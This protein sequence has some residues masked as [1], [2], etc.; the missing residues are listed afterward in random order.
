[1]IDDPVQPSPPDPSGP[2]TSPSPPGPPSASSPPSPPTPSA[3]PG[4]QEK[5]TGWVIAGVV[6]VVILCGILSCAA[7]LAAGL[8]F[9]ENAEVRDAVEQAEGHYSKAIEAIERAAEELDVSFVDDV[10]GA[11]IRE[12]ADAANKKL[13]IARDEIAAARVT[14]E[15]LDESEGRTHY[16]ASLDASTEAIDAI[17]DMVAYTVTM[18]EMA[19]YITEGADAAA[20]AQAALD[21]AVE[22]SNAEAYSKMRSE[23]QEAASEYARAASAFRAAHRVDELAEIDKAAD[24]LDIRKEQAEM[25]VRM[26]DDGQAGRT[27]AFNKGVDRVRELDAEADAIGEPAIVADPNWGEER[28]THLDAVVQSAGDRADEL[29]RKA[30]EAFGY[31]Y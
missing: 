3:A 19:D 16:I 30:L 5:R 22:A 18:G 20:R 27:E 6:G 26:S 1:M 29:R 21:D 31:N 24:F 8:M 9:G 11:V 14:I 10:D 28:L 23:A 13:R 17:E 12:L 25:L 2:P 4:P 7:L 15:R